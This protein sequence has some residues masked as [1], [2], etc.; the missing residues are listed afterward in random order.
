MKPSGLTFAFL[1]VF[2]MAIMYN[3]VQV[4]ADADADAEAEALAN[5]LAEA[6]ILMYQGLGEKSDGLDQGQNGKVVAKK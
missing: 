3:S 1:V 4:T 6:G 5:A 2:M